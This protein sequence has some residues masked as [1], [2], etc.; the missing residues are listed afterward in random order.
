VLA[1]LQYLRAVRSFVGE[2]HTL[3]DPDELDGLPGRGGV[4]QLLEWIE[5]TAAAPPELSEHGCSITEVVAPDLLAIDGIAG[6]AA[7]IH[8]ANNGARSTPLRAW[9]AVYGPTAAGMTL[10]AHA[11]SPQDRTLAPGESAVITVPFSTGIPHGR[12]EPLLL[13]ARVACGP[14]LASAVATSAAEGEHFWITS[15]EDDDGLRGATNHEI[16]DSGTVAPAAVA[17]TE[18]EIGGA[19]QRVAFRLISEH[20]DLDLHVWGPGDQHVGWSPDSSQDQV[21]LPGATY[22]GSGADP[23]EIRVS[24]PGEATVLRIE[25]RHH[26]D[27]AVLPATA[28]ASLDDA[29]PGQEVPY[30]VE[31]V[32]VNATDP[33]L[34]ASPNHVVVGAPE[35]RDDLLNRSV[36]GQSRSETNRC[37]VASLGVRSLSIPQ[38]CC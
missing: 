1:P 35:L 25:V 30:R 23:E 2:L 18:L 4:L 11:E 16:I 36:A 5:Q 37:T 24:L 9:G 15:S 34:T 29:A 6:G 19:R 20:G 26:Q 27:D 32:L 14:S 12:I 22:S 13:D 8:V 3:W 21:E 28:W 31:A 10:L 33:L 7:E 17:S 38:I